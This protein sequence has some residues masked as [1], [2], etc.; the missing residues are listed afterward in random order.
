MPPRSANAASRLITAFL[1]ASD[2]ATPI[3][4]INGA[5]GI[6]TPG[7]LDETA[8]SPSISQCVIKGSSKISRRKPNPGVMVVNPH[9]PGSIESMS[10]CRRSP[11]CTPLTY[12]GPVNACTTFRFTFPRS[13]A[14]VAGV[15]SPSRAFLVIMTTSSPGLTSK[16]GGIA[17]CH[18]L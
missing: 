4:P 5:P 1:N 15:T 11:G 17:G 9:F 7:R 18:L 2:G 13:A 16:A 14:V 3:I 8:Q 6:R 10:I 12:T